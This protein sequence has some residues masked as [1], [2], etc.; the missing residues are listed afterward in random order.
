MKKKKIKYFFIITLLVG[1]LVFLDFYNIIY[2]HYINHK[3]K[4]GFRPT[5]YVYENLKI[6]KFLENI[7]NIEEKNVTIN[8]IRP[9]SIHHA[10]LSFYDKEKEVYYLVEID[11]HMSDKMETEVLFCYV[12]DSVAKMNTKRI[13]MDY[14]YITNALITKRFESLVIENLKGIKPSYVCIPKWEA[15]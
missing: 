7:K 2:Y 8:F 5:A 15:D 14:D 13:N 9:N 4:I 6:T 1:I 12:A 10:G 11:D 3:P